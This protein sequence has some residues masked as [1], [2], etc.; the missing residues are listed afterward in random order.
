MTLWGH[1]SSTKNLKKYSLIT[2]IG[3]L[4]TAIAMTVVALITQLHVSGSLLCAGAVLLSSICSGAMFF[5]EQRVPY[6]EEEN[7]Y[8]LPHGEAHEIW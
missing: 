5:V 6:K 8:K 1:H 4:L 7:D 3:Q 2:S